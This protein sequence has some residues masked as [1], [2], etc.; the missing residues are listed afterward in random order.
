[1]KSSALSPAFGASA[2]TRVFAPVALPLRFGPELPAATKPAITLHVSPHGD[3]AGPGTHPKPFASLERCREAIRALKHWGPLPEGGV[4]VWIHGGDYE[5]TETFRLEVE[6]S[7]T[8][9]APVRYAAAPEERPVFRGGS[10]VQDWRRLDDA[11]AYPL[12]PTEARDHVW[13]ADL[14]A[15]SPTR[16]TSCSST[17][18]L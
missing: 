15:S 9:A 6:D 18:A 12:L 2:D 1:M 11:T 7:G 17:V 16:R 14:K 10:R 8:A 13:V 4:L 3:D 5:V